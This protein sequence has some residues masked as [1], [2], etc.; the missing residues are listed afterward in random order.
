[1]HPRRHKCELS[2]IF[3]F[4]TSVMWALSPISMLG[5]LQQLKKCCFTRV[6]FRKPEVRINSAFLALLMNLGVD[7]GSTVTDYLPEER[8]RGITIKAA[9]ITFPW[10]KRS[11]NLIDT[12]GHAD[13]TFEV[14]RS[15]RVLDG[16]VAILD[17]VAGVEAQTEKVWRQADE[18]NLSRIAFVNKMDREGA[19]FGR[20]VR[21]I[22]SRLGV[23]PIVMQLPVFEGGLEGG[24]FIGMLDLLDLT[25]F[26]WSQTDGKAR[27]QATPLHEYASA[28]ILHEAKVARTAMMEVLAELDDN[29]LDLYVQHE[30]NVKI[31]GSSIRSAI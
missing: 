26:T 31:P 27:V 20:T 28:S 21:E 7:D 2:R 15:L 16:A 10:A 1:M 9:A 14:S 3:P 12:P 4:P 5:R 22:A 29:I 6:T 25:V 23:R 19:G 8:A 24:R 17:A 18:W 13:F 30:D 11:I